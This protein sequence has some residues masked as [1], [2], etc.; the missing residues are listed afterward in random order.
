MKRLGTILVGKLGSTNLR[1]LILLV[2]LASVFGALVGDKLF[3]PLGLRSMAY[4][5]P[6]LGLL[7]LAMMIALLSGGLDLSI[8]ATANLAALTIAEVL[9]A[10]PFGVTGVNADLWSVLAILA[11]LA[12]ALVVGL[13]N[14]LLIAHLRVSP[15][16][17][18]LGTMTLVKGLEIGLTHGSVL[19]GFPPAIVFLGNGTLVGVPIPI[20]LFVAAAIPLGVLLGRTPLGIGIALVGSNQRAVRYSGIDPRAVQMRVYMLSSLLSAL[21]GIVM[22]ARFDSANAAYGES[23][24]L[25]T[26]LAGVLGGVSPMG[27]YGTVGGLVI[28]LAILQLISTA[29]ILLDLSQF[30]T[31]S[32]W[33]GILLVV[34]FVTRLANWIGAFRF[35]VPAPI[36]KTTTEIV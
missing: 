18:T 22:M 13:L 4:Q 11:G 7:S 33:G 1:L 15:I 31:L 25:L 16:L 5:L 17:A 9:H 36:E 20:I 34:T 8:I 6:E 21:A 2:V 32:L 35:L 12:A 29:C 24:L 14:G 30:L 10:S 28:A 26:I 27:G 3:G 23:Y 19:S